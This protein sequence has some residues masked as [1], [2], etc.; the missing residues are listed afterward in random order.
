MQQF[1]KY[2]YLFAML[3]FSTLALPMICEAETK[4]S[5]DG[6]SIRT[7]AP[8]GLRFKITVTDAQNA[9]DCGMYLTYGG[10][11]V[12]VSTRDTRYQNIY[13]V[14]TVENT[15]EY[16]VVVHDIPET[17]FEHNFSVKG[18][19]VY[20]TESGDEEQ[21]TTMETRSIQTVAEAA[22]YEYTDGVWTRILEKKLTFD[23][24]NLMTQ[25]NVSQLTYNDDGSVDVKVNGAW[26][27]VAFYLDPSKSAVDLS[28]YNKAIVNI[29]GEDSFG[30]CINMTKT[31]DIW[32]ECLGAMYATANTSSTTI[33]YDLAPYS[34][35]SAYAILV[36]YNS[37]SVPAD[38]FTMHIDSITLVREVRDITA[39]TT[40]YKPL[41]NLAEKFGFKMGTVMNPTK[42]ADSKYS[43]LM[44]YHFNSITA[45]NEMKAYSM[46]DENESKKAY[47]NESSMPVINFTNADKFMDFAQAEGISVR[48]HALVWDA[49]MCDW[50]FREGYTRDGAYVSSDVIKARVKNY[51]E[52]VLTHFETKY[53][54]V[55]YCWDVVNEAVEPSNKMDAEDNRGIENNIFSQRMGSDYVELS[56][57]Y[58]RECLETLGAADRVKLYYNDFNTF[59]DA[60]R[61]AIC[62]LVDSINSYQP[63]G[64]G[65]YIKLCDGVG[66]QSYIGGY[67][68]QNGCMN[69]GDI[70]RVKNAIQAFA[71]HN[72][73]VQVTEL[74]VRNY[75]NSA[76]VL[77]RH[78]EF[79]KKLFEMYIN[80]NKT[81]EEKPLK[82]I[83]I[84]GIVDIPDLD[85]NDYSFSMNGPYCGLFDDNLSV[86]DSFVN[87][88][89]LLEN[90]PQ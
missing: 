79:Y 16:T 45:S 57:Q 61:D 70:T 81:N 86:K 74:A 68:T 54:G 24:T 75:E 20:R 42:I 43:T 21:Q 71:S 80:I 27:K 65:G 35:D 18:F 29:S 56:F 17:A 33:S 22:G 53:P 59:Y 63:D 14:N 23:Q 9:V 77:E 73:E 85:R 49:D 7:E 11:T 13:R 60:K 4:V 39:A 83:S 26:G 10:K 48:G 28:E 40:Q 89:N 87:I 6:A 34:G 52:Q 44:K 62:H 46:L 15:V 31:T 1:K 66:M 58:T 76:D 12:E 32:N 19:A 36:Q 82:A 8:Q 88:Y 2:I 37:S 84:W 64:K 67:G 25:H 30:V 3:C 51:I 47:I 55:I 78:A 38:D 69:D 90:T 50:F 72:V 41:A 5:F